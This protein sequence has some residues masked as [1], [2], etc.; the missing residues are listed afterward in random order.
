MGSIQVS[1]GSFHLTIL[2]TR[3]I[4]WPDEGACEA[5]ARRVAA[6]PGLDQA[7][8]T[9]HGSL[10]AGKT[11]F[12]RHLLHA[13]GISGAIKSPTYALVE[14]YRVLARPGLA[15]YPVS[16]FDFYRFQDPHEWEDAGLRELFAAPGLKLV[17]WPE[18]AEGLLPQADLVVT[19]T[20]GSGEQRSARFDA[21]SPL[22]RTLLP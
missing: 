14:G 6:R 10:G 17:E 7:L 3:T 2:E 9:L 18:M 19:I 1:S 21:L 15:G 13:L 5:S 20:P 16:H 12:T 11:T 8:L 4:P 22:G